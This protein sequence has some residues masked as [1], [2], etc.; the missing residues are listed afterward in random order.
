MSVKAS[1]H[2]LLA[3]E[4]TYTLSAHIEYRGQTVSV[5]ENQTFHWEQDAERQRMLHLIREGKG[6]RAEIDTYIRTIGGQLYRAVFGGPE[7]P[8]KKAL[9]DLQRV[10]YGHSVR[11]VLTITSIA[12]S[13]LPWEALYDDQY[14]SVRGDMPLVRRMP[15]QTMS[16]NRRP[17]QG[18]LQVLLVWASPIGLEIPKLAETTARLKQII[19]Q[20]VKRSGLFARRMKVTIIAHV[21]L[22]KLRAELVRNPGKYHILCFAGHGTDTALCFESERTG[23]WPG[24]AYE[25]SAQ[26]FAEHINTARLSLLL[27]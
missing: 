19:E 14:L 23:A 16:P 24:E 5:V 10:H 22:E 11:L 13:E 18:T 3:G 4:T 9:Q 20:D 27:I 6:N 25:V 26:T 12:L 8:L 15:R 17:I 2:L 21:S 7:N 1:L